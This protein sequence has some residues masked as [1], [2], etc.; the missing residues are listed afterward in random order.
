MEERAARALESSRADDRL[1]GEKILVRTDI[2]AVFYGDMRL[3]SNRLSRGYG[4][5]EVPTPLNRVVVVYGA[6]FFLLL[7]FFCI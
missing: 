2:R 7:H 1:E 6:V 3:S 4:S 5:G